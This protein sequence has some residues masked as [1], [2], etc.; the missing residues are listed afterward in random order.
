MAK[1]LGSKLLEPTLNSNPYSSP[2]HIPL[3]Y[4][5]KISLYIPLKGSRVSIFLNIIPV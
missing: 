3:G 1:G 5:P 2:L 4:N